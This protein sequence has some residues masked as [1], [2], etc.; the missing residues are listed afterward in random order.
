[1]RGKQG[2]K[3]HAETEYRA[4]AT[5]YFK[6]GDIIFLALENGEAVGFIRVSSRDGSFWIEELFVRPDFRGRGIGRALAERAEKEVL[7]WDSA[8][9]LLILPQDKDAI[10]FWKSSATTR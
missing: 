1:M 9:Y 5:H 4:E 2:W 10:A 7:K 6:R 8:L 3:P